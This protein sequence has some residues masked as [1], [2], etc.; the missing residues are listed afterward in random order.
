[1][2]SGF[3][4]PADPPCTCEAEDGRKDHF[5]ANAVEPDFAYLFEILIWKPI[6][7]ELCKNDLE[8]NAL[9]R[10]FG[11]GIRREPYTINKNEVESW[12][13]SHLSP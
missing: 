2:A 3:K 8:Y 7:K 1:D 11:E 9:G 5:V 6:F 13:N 4:L 10:K 12:I